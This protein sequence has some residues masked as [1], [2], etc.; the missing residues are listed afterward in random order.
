M[1]STKVLVLAWYVVSSAGVSGLLLTLAGLK[2]QHEIASA[3]DARSSLIRHKYNSG[4]TVEFIKTNVNVK[5]VATR[6]ATGFESDNSRVS[7]TNQAGQ[8]AITWAK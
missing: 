5:S 6:I 2:M 4:F 3:A 1:H 7:M 8:Y